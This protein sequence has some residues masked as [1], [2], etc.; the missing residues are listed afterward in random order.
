MTENFAN[1]FIDHVSENRG[2]NDENAEAQAKILHFF[3]L[4]FEFLGYISANR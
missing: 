1:Q 3:F 2:T 4:I